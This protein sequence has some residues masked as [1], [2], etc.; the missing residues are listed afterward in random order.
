M[1]QEMMMEREVMTDD[2]AR[3]NDGEISDDGERSDDGQRMLL[4]KISRVIDRG[5]GEDVLLYCEVV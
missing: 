4:K 1:V 3:S 5:G 2:G